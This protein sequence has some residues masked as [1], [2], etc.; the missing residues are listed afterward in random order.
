MTLELRTVPLDELLERPAE[1]NPKRHDRDAIRASLL[2]HGFVEPVLIDERTGRLVG[3]H[4]RLEVLAELRTEGVDPPDGITVHRGDWRVPAVHGYRSPDDGHARRLLIALNRTGELGGWDLE[5]LTA[6]LEA[7]EDLTATG[8]TDDDLAGLRDRLAEIEATETADV[9]RDLDDPA[10]YGEP[11][12]DPTAQAGDVWTLGDHGRLIVGDCLES[13]TLDRLLDGLE[14]AA[15]VT[16]PPYAIYGSATGIA[17]D[18]AD[19]KMVRPFFVEVLRIARDRLPWFAHAY[20]FTD[21]RSWAALWEAGKRAGVQVR[22]MLVWDKGGGGRGSNYAN[23]HEL[24]AFLHKLPEQTAM[25]DRPAG[26]KSVHRP[27]I[28]RHSRPTGAERLHNAAK[29]VALLGELIENSTEAGAWVLDPFAGSG[30]TLIAAAETGRR[31]ALVELEPKM[32]DVILRRWSRY[33]EG[34]DPV[35]HDGKRL[36]E[37]EG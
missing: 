23:A 28:L 31:A 21:W 17:S 33:T 8:Y 22:N 14:L 5:E 2:D 6:E 4:G 13:D 11:P 7:L 37:L 3:G 26:V 32:A 24:V 35:R 12:E 19:D 9:D 25:G 20:V 29:P 36:S 27:N 1:R 16:D 18:I 30:S 34:G 10:D 15:I